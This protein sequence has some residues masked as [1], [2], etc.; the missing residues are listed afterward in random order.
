M[1]AQVPMIVIVMPLVQ[2]LLEDILVPVMQD[3]QGME[4]CVQV[5][6]YCL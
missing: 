4:E 1:S 3:L 5:G 6:L 2:T